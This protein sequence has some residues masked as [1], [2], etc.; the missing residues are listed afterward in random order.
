MTIQP[1][2]YLAS[3]ALEKNRWSSREPSL[4]VS[5]YIQGAKEAGFDGIELWENHFIRNSP[6]E[7]AILKADAFTS[8]IFNTYCIFEDTE[9]SSQA[10]HKLLETIQQLK[11][12]GLKWNI[13]NDPAL[14]EIY[15]KNVCEVVSKLPPNFR[16]LCECH[17]GT[18]L[19]KPEEAVKFLNQLEARTKGTGVKISAIVHPFTSA[20]AELT[21]WFESL[22]PKLAHAHCQIRDRQNSNYFSDLK[23]NEKQILEA[24]SFMKKM[25]YEGTWSIEFVKA[26]RTPNDEAGFLFE[27]TKTELISLKNYLSLL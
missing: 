15:L 25:N 23:S 18:L 27:Q 24:L 8:K 2:I 11:P 21:K 13:G 10:R 22:G 3:V 14:Y 1:T 17:P 20:P 12:L 19:E 26:T 4:L 5:Q 16:F 7:Q 6:E 9:V